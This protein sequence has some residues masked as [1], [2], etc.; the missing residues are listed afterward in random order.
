MAGD[1]PNSPSQALRPTSSPD[2]DRAG[3]RAW[4]WAVVVLAVMVAIPL[5]GRILLLLTEEPSRQLVQVTERAAIM[6]ARGWEAAT[7]I[8][9]DH[10]YLTNG[11]ATLVVREAAD[12]ASASDELQRTLREWRADR[13]IQLVTS[14]SEPADIGPQVVAVRA[15]FL[16][17]F[18]GVDYPVEGELTVVEGGSGAVVVFRAWASKGEFQLVAPDVDA[19]IRSATYA[20]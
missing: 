10:A 14:S 12:A 18:P 4:L 9:N 6:P 15:A 5:S 20:P 16:G 3:R 1:R 2:D 8:G 7:P 13:D 17:I 11:S 19:M